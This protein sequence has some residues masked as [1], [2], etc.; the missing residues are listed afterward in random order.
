MQIH[1]PTRLACLPGGQGGACPFLI[2]ELSNLPVCILFGS[3]L[4]LLTRFVYLPSQRQTASSAQ[5]VVCNCQRAASLEV[6]LACAASLS[7]ACLPNLEGAHP[8]V[9]SALSTAPPAVPNQDLAHD[10]CLPVRCY[11]G[12]PGFC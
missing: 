4:P 9:C 5:A 1:A 2:H 3:L 10:T 7:T 11:N 12:I 6:Y 8:N